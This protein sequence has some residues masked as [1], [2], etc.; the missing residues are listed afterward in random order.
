MSLDLG[1]RSQNKIKKTEGGVRQV[2]L[3]SGDSDSQLGPDPCL[4]VWSWANFWASLLV[5]LTLIKWR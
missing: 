1:A 3:V 4:A 5:S 2:N